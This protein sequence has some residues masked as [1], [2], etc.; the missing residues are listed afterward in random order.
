MINVSYSKEKPG[1]MNIERNVSDGLEDIPTLTE[2]CVHALYSK[3]VSQPLV[4]E[5]CAYG[6]DRVNGV[7]LGPLHNAVLTHLSKI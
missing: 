6:I 3:F 7:S 5:L 2:L 1:L 4:Q